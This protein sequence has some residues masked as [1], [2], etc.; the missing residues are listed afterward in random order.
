MEGIREWLG[1]IDWFFVLCVLLPTWIL[2]ALMGYALCWGTHKQR[3]IE[4][5]RPITDNL[6][7]PPAPIVVPDT[8]PED[9]LAPHD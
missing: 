1:Y 7:R 4:V 3:G 6:P 8:I 5:D 2:W 9:W